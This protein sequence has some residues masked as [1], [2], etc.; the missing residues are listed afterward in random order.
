MFMSYKKY[1]GSGKFTPQQLIIMD[2]QEKANKKSSN[3]K[4]NNIKPTVLKCEKCGVKLSESD[5]AV[6]EEKEFEQPIYCDLCAS[7]NSKVN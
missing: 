7:G 4:I 5:I 2:Q 6:M 3:E 1:S